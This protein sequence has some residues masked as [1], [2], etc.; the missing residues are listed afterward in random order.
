MTN[1]D[2]DVVEADRSTSLGVDKLMLAVNGRPVDLLI[3]NAG[4]GLGHGFLD[5]PFAEAKHV[6]DTDIT[7]TLGVLHRIVTKMRKR[8]AGRILARARSRG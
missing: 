2:V 7:G 3:A 1:V 6:I 8:N 4:H 5:K